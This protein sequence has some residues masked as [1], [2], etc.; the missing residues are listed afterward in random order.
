[1]KRVGPFLA[2][3]LMLGAINPLLAQPAYPNKPIKLI[4]EFP[5]GSVADIVARIV[6]PKLGDGLGQP[7][8]VENKPGAGGSIGADF[9]VRSAPDGYTLLLSGANDTSNAS[10]YKLSFN[11]ARDL[12]PIALIGESPGLLVAHPSGPNGVR[13]LIAAANANP[14]Q[15]PYASSSPGTIAHLWG[16][17]FGLETGAK[18]TH[19]PYK[20]AAPATVDLLAGR[21]T[22]QFAPASTVVSHVKA[23]KLKAFATIGRK[24]LE[25]L[26]DVPT[27]A[28]LG[29][30]G[31]DAALWVGLS[32]PAGTPEAVIERLNRETVRVLDLPEL[33]S[34]FAAQSINPLPSTSE[35]YGTLIR[36]DM[37]KWANVIRTANIKID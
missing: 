20:G 8:V 6:A 27:L 28:E 33:K 11:V 12:A 14:G 36:Q 16:E 37:E 18:L 1:M 35:Q 7:V 34:Q 26:P 19:I 17:L 25:A 21:V 3:V 29:I 32:A 15:I 2:A 9:V 10:L 31:F 24:R 5:P 13:E 22:V 4:V 30:K 23:G